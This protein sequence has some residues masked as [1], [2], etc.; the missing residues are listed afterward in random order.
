MAD[1][2][3]QPAINA[4]YHCQNKAEDM[5]ADCGSAYQL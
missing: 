5:M 2:N 1:N 3:Q 4:I